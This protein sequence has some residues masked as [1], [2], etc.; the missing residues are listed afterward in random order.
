[1]DV[2]NGYARRKTHF[3]E[4]FVPAEFILLQLEKSGHLETVFTPRVVRSGTAAGLQKPG[5]WLATLTLR[6]G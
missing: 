1:M 3:K 5:L 4:M 6:H 2:G